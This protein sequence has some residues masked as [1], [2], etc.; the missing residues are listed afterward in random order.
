MPRR[1]LEKF[2]QIKISPRVFH[3][4]DFAGVE[5]E[6]F[7]RKHFQNSHPLIVEVG[8][9]YGEYTIGLAQAFPDC[10]VVG[11]D[12]KGD[13]IWQGT[14]WADQHNLHNVAF[15]QGR[16]E[17][18]AH[19]FPFQSV[20]ELWITF[21]DPQPKKPRQ[22][23]TH[24]KFLEQYKQVLRARNHC[25]LK[26][27]DEDFFNF[28]RQVLQTHGIQHK[29]TYDVYQSDLAAKTLGIYT[30]YEKT[31]IEKGHTI[32]FLECVV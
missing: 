8:C 5:L 12:I 3:Y 19:Y 23:I 14:Q 26:T 11:I 6:H 20:H 17:A 27:D 10:N 25:Y 7:W 31:W 9:G 18:I 22:R 24:P 2:A 1:K 21:P 16:V 13:R 28:T 29:G 4:V 30:R 32:K 15:I